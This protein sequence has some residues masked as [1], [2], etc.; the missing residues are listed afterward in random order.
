MINKVI[1]VGRITKDPELNF[2]NGDIPLVKFVL[3]VNRKFTN[4]AGIK[5]TDFINCSVWNKNAENLAK[6]V[7]KG[8]L[9]GIEGSIRISSYENNNQKKFWTEIYCDNVQFLDSKKNNLKN[10][11]EYSDF[12]NQNETSKNINDNESNDQLVIG[13]EDD[14]PF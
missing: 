2:I 10:D 7:V 8:S 13:N 11:N 12:Q 5:E 3:A 1:L 6:F 4:K 14:L 9:L